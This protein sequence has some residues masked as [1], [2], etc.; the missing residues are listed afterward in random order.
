MGG[1][2]SGSFSDDGIAHR[3][4]RKKKS[5]I[6]VSGSGEP[7][8]VPGLSKGASTI[9][10]RIAEVVSGVAFVQDS[11]ALGVMAELMHDDRALRQC[12]NE[13]PVGSE[14]YD[15]VKRLQLANIRAIKD[16]MNH[17]GMTPRTRQLLLV[18]KEER[19]LDEYEKMLQEDGG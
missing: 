6:A 9:W 14:E 5:A 7:V 15:V 3:G 4:G 8:K 11:E 10:D 13:L 16:S 17:F 2:G 12:M 18:P 19:E 1:K